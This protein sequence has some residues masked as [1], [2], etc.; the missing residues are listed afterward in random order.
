MLTPGLVTSPT[1]PP[2]TYIPDMEHILIRFGINPL[3]LKTV[4]LRNYHWKHMDTD[5]FSLSHPE[6]PPPFPIELP[7]PPAPLQEQNLNK[8]PTPITIHKKFPMHT[9]GLVTSPTSLSDTYIP[10]MEQILIKFGINPS[11]LKTVN[12][13]NYHWKHV[14]TLD[15]SLV[16]SP[17]ISQRISTL[18]REARITYRYADNTE[19]Y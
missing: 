10:D 3:K 12:L 15:E 9:P 8:S 11:K 18:V 17:T 1:S 5:I 2:D 19:F 7:T 16:Q 6:P 13:R 14:C 4:N